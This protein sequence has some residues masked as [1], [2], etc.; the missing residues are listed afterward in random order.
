MGNTDTP[1]RRRTVAAGVVAG[2]ALAGMGVLVFQQHQ[3]IAELRA[4]AK[5]QSAQCDDPRAT[6]QKHLATKQAEN[7]RLAATVVLQNPTCFS[8]EE[9]AAAQTRITNDS[10]EAAREALCDAS[11]QPFWKC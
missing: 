6:T 9:R 1:V 7:I 11:G 4:A 2:A 3:E 5:G 8:A 10:Q